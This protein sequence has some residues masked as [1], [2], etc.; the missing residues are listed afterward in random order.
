MVSE[1]K[2]SHIVST[3]DNLRLQ[4]PCWSALA[5]QRRFEPTVLVLA[6]Y[7]KQKRNIFRRSVFVLVA[8]VGFETLRIGLNHIL[9][10]P[11]F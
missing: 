6:N 11:D 5:P 4:Q 3:H 9:Y 2:F 7:V 10:I 1:N 8:G